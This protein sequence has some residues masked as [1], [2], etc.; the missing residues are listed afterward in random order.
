MSK[1]NDD[2]PKKA[3]KEL[4]QRLNELDTAIFDALPAKVTAKTVKNLFNDLSDDDCDALANS[5]NSTMKTAFIRVSA[6]NETSNGVVDYDFNAIKNILSHLTN[7]SSKVLYYAIEHNGE[8]DDPN[9]HF[10]IVIDFKNSPARFSNLKKNYFP[11]G[12]IE[13]AK[14]LRASIQYLIHLNDLDKEQLSPSCIYSNDSA[15]HL[16]TY[17]YR[18]PKELEK[19]NVLYSY[20]YLI[21]SG[22]IR[23]FNKYN[24]IPSDV[25]NGFESKI[26]RAIDTYQ[27]RKF[28]ANCVNRNI[29]VICFEGRPGIGKTVIAKSLCERAGLSYCISGAS[30]DPLESYLGEDVFIFDDIRSSHFSCFTDLINFLD[31]NTGRLSRA[32]YKSK[33]FTGNLIILTCVHLT[34]LYYGYRD[35]DNHFDEV[36]S[37]LYRRIPYKF[38]LYDDGFGRYGSFAIS[39]QHYDLDYNHY[40]IDDKLYIDDISKYFCSCSNSQIDLDISKILDFSDVCLPF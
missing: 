21:D 3:S 17:L 39:C 10:H 5:L 28:Y 22:V 37:Q 12:D 32:R 4:L 16:G 2:K 35:A 20:L 8:T 13:T 9:K 14:S 27:K 7:N 34:D 11:Y 23:G 36:D 18:T 24:K 15:I 25:L 31:N 6:H 33:A 19:T 26:D 1:K 29:K 40:V 38:S 30:N